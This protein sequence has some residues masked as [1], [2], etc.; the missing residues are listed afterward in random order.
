[1]QRVFHSAFC[2]TLAMTSAL[3]DGSRNPSGSDSS[4]GWRP[5]DP[6]AVYHPSPAPTPTDISTLPR[7]Q[8]ESERPTANSRVPAA[9]MPYNGELQYD[10]ATEP[11]PYA[12]SPYPYPPAGYMNEWGYLADPSYPFGYYQAPVYSYPYQDG[13]APG[14]SPY[15]VPADYDYPASYGQE[16]YYPTQPAPGYGTGYYPGYENGGY[17]NPYGTAQP[18]TPGVDRALPFPPSRAVREAYPTYGQPPDYP[19]AQAQPPDDPYPLPIGATTADNPPHGEWRPLNQ[20]TAPDAPV[21]PAVVDRGSYRI[22]GAPAI[23][24][25]WT[26]PADETAAGQPAR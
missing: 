6:P 19:A 12:Q 3:A 2:L 10:G 21:P 13:A 15:E 20:G 16:Y 9:Q 22:N 17:G 26:D 23:F 7:Y 24:R 11:E 5:I 25:P 18:Q 4:N 14:Y 1:M 8:N